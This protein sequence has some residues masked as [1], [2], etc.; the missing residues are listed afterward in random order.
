MQHFK[1]TN[2]QLVHEKA[3]FA[4]CSLRYENLFKIERFTP[5]IDTVCYFVSFCNRL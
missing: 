2:V 3:P 5:E 1:K 4:K